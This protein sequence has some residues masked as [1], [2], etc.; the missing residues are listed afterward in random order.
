MISNHGSP[1]WGWYP[2]L[3]ATHCVE[4]QIVTSTIARTARIWPHKIRD[5]DMAIKVQKPSHAI[6]KRASYKDATGYVS[7]GCGCQSTCSRKK[8][9]GITN[10][11]QAAI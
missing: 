1:N 9:R 7:D 8:V 5:A 6:D 11:I 2:S 3:Q 10:Q 4:A